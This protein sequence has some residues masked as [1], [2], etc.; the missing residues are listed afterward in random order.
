MAVALWPWPSRWWS[1]VVAG[2]G[3]PGSGLCLYGTI[4]CRRTLTHSSRVVAAL[5]R[6]N[7]I[8][9]A[10]AESGRTE[11]IQSKRE[12]KSRVGGEWRVIGAFTIYFSRAIQRACVR[13]SSVVAEL[14]C[15]RARDL[16]RRTE[17]A[18]KY[19]R[20]VVVGMS[21]LQVPSLMLR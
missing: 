12:Q 13:A 20:S 9:S 16:R 3:Q 11:H 6:D 21:Q 10:A 5:R 14:I 8:V 17:L 15:Q 18:C 1:R 2:A 4:T 19:Q 7:R